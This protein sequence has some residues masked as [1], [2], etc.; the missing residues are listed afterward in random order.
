[1]ANQV[2]ACVLR[3]VSLT[4]START[5]SWEPNHLLSLTLRY[6]MHPRIPLQLYTEPPFNGPGQLR[7]I[8]TSAN[9]HSVLHVSPSVFSH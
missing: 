3:K 5:L 7:T 4:K 8:K 6:S 9:E 1:M 2:T